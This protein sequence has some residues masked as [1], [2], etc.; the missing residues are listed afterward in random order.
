M[1]GDDVNRALT[2]PGLSKT[3]LRL[4]AVTLFTGL[5]LSTAG[6]FDTE[7]ASFGP[8]L[9]YW[10]A[11]AALST[12]ALELVHRLLRRRAPA[13][14]DWAVRLIGWSV[15]VLP[16]N[17]VAVLT[18]KLLFGGWPT[19]G[20]FLYLLPGMAAILAALQFVLLTFEG[21]ARF[22]PAAPAGVPPQA[23]PVAH[24]GRLSER[25]PLPLRQAMI[26]AIE[27]E[28]H[29]VRIHTS[30][31]AA[32]IRMRFQDAVELMGGQAGARPHRSWWVAHAA[33]SAMQ[34]DGNRTFILLKGGQRVPV[35]RN[36][37]AELG[38]LF[39]PDERG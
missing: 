5:L 29:Y 37:R 25:L 22:T 27:A 4:L 32:F 38:P 33:M 35:S 20:G 3:P 19:L 36:A 2:H 18:C 9:G 23:E 16:L 13:V 10:T 31:G 39:G 34:R 17:M 11:I 26:E 6:A 14:P 30:A 24:A 12:C 8:R 15:L 28:D 1:T 7:A 21:A